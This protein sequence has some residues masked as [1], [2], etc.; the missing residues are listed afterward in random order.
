MEKSSDLWG[1]VWLAE[2]F[3][4]RHLEAFLVAS[5]CPVPWASVG[6]AKTMSATGLCGCIQ[7]VIR[8]DW[9]GGLGMVGASFL[10]IIT[11]ETVSE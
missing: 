4:M 5:A 2:V 7:P 11:M 1:D 8:W 10:V 9:S 3:G 6:S